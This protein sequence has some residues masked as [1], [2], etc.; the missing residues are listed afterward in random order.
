MPTD[1]CTC[2]NYYH[3]KKYINMHCTITAL[4]TI[5]KLCYILQI[6]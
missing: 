3:F 2:S 6:S 4:Q 5:K 1:Y